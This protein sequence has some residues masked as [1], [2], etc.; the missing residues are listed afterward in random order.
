MEQEPRLLASI[1]GGE[2][3]GKQL[4]LGAFWWRI[5]SEMKAGVRYDL[6]IT[7]QLALLFLA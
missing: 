1:G 2:S 4:P 6:E 3:V 5:L 7:L